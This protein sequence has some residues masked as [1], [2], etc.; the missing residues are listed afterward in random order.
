MTTKARIVRDEKGRVT[1]TYNQYGAV[2]IREVTYDES[3]TIESIGL[4]HDTDFVRAPNGS[5]T[6]SV[7]NSNLDR[8]ENITQLRIDQNNGTFYYEDPRLSRL[9]ALPAEKCCNLSKV[10]IAKYSQGL[11]LEEV[12][13]FGRRSVSSYDKGHAYCRIS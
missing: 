3:G 4:F 6:R 12:R 2:V 11:V 10:C 8:V 9:F 1:A 7:K 13:D 5:Y